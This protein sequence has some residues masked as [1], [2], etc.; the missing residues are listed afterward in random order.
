MT[1]E[2]PSRL[3]HAGGPVAAALCG[4][5]MPPGFFALCQLRPVIERLLWGA[6]PA[7]VQMS[8]NVYAKQDYFRFYLMAVAFIVG[9]GGL[10]APIAEVK[11]GIGGVR[12]TL[13][14][15]LL[16]PAAE[17]AATVTASCRVFRC[18]HS[19]VLIGGIPG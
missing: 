13:A 12:H 2:L 5:A 16:S 4:M 10:L 3:S 1:I 18:A 19:G 14:L 8:N 7:P 9:F 11:L 17:L 6:M 15:S